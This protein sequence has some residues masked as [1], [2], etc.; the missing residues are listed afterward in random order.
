VAQLIPEPLLVVA[1][2]ARE[3]GRVLLTQRLEGSHLG[4][5]W[6]LPGGKL[7]PGEEPSAA[8]SRE[9]AEELGCEVGDIEPFCFS[10]HSYPEKT[11][12]LLCYELRL[13]TPPHPCEGQR[14]AW[15][16]LEDL[17]EQPMPA[18]DQVL[19]EKLLKAETRKARARG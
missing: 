7:R 5:L 11:V 19:I 15:V 3:R 1:G 10:W 4:G 8:L 12:L 16:A 18:A 6:E 13:K 14:M 2:I 17:P 9:W